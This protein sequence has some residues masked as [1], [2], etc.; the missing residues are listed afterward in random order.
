M[1][2]GVLTGEE[3]AALT[4]EELLGYF[5]GWKTAAMKELLARDVALKEAREA[6]RPFAEIGTS[7]D[8]AFDYYTPAARFNPEFS[9]R[10]VAAARKAMGWDR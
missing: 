5:F 2:L 10:Q 4:H 6:L 8:R 7:P 9:H 1:T 3:L